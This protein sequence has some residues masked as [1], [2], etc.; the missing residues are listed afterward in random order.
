LEGAIINS[1]KVDGLLALVFLLHYFRPVLPI[2]FNTGTGTV[3]I[4]QFRH[5]A[6]IYQINYYDYF[7]CKLQLEAYCYTWLNIDFTNKQASMVKFTN[8][9][10]VN[11]H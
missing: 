1:L 7:G 4:S 5:L 6:Y 11:Y 9:S 10:T 8:L 2:S 3:T